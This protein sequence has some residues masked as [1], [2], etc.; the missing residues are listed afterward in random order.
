MPTKTLPAISLRQKEIV[1]DYL[2]QLDKHI[3]DL[4]NGTAE[5]TFEIKDLADLLHIHPTHL[6]NTI[7]QVLG[8]SPCDLYEQKLVTISKELLLASNRP[9]AEIARQL[10]YDPSNF[11]KFFKHFEGITPKQFREANLSIG[12]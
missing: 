4:K 8:Q 1:K 3:A 7:S 5:S 10:S 11:T 12:A 6:S 9:I 2:T